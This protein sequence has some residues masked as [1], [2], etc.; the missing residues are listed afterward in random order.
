MKLETQTGDTSKTRRIILLVA[1]LGLS[2]FMYLSIM[3]K[4]IN[5]GP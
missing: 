3:Y 5:Y 4:I 2:A 1:L